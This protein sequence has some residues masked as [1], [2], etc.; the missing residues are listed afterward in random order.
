MLPKMVRAHSQRDLFLLSNVLLF[1]SRESLPISS[2][3][4]VYGSSGNLCIT[5]R[6]MSLL[7]EAYFGGFNL[8]QRPAR[9]AA[10]Y[11]HLLSLRKIMS[12]IFANSPFVLV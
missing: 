12:N 6:Y 2:L 4:Q 10:K 9:L 1:F 3:K 7:K 8:K 11:M 5:A